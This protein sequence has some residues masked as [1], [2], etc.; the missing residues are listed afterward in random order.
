MSNEY[1]D[2]LNDLSE[3]QRANYQL[4]MNYPF[5]LHPEDDNYDYEY[6]PVNIPKGWEN[7]FIDMCQKLKEILIEHNALNDYYFLDVKEKYFGLVC[8]ANTYI[9]EAEELFREYIKNNHWV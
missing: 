4:C 1:K 6:F 5:L 7:L 9:E 3:E 8:Y 2:W